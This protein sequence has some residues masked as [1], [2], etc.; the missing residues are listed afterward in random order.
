MRET[1]EKEG[2]GSQTVWRWTLQGEDN[3]QDREKPKGP[4]GMQKASPERASPAKWRRDVKDAW[5]HQRVQE[6]LS[7][8]SEAVEATQNVLE[9]FCLIGKE[10]NSIWLELGIFGYIQSHLLKILPDYKLHGSKVPI[11]FISALRP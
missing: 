8:S 2:R 7:Q 11:H 5:N 4:G 6:G 1:S 10:R 3:W 9:F